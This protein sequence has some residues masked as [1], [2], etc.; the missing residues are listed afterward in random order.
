MTTDTAAM[1]PP[2]PIMVELLMVPE[3]ELEEGEPLPLRT[4]VWPAGQSAMLHDEAL[5][6]PLMAVVVPDGHNVH[7]LRIRTTS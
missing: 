1:P 4:M 2:M 6:A 5:V 7:T 3:R